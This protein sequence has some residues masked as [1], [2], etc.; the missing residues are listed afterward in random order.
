MDET[1]LRAKKSPYCPL[2]RK[3]LRPQRNCRYGVA[4]MTE[5]MHELDQEKLVALR[6]HTHT[7]TTDT[8]FT[9][10]CVDDASRST[11]VHGA[12]RQK[13]P[14]FP[15]GDNHADTH[16]F[17]ELDRTR[18]ELL[19]ERAANVCRQVHP[20]N[21]SHEVEEVRDEVVRY[22]TILPELFL[23]DCREDIQKA[24]LTNHSHGFDLLRSQNRE[25]STLIRLDDF[26]VDESRLDLELFV[27]GRTLEDGCQQLVKIGSDHVGGLNRFG[28]MSCDPQ[29]DRKLQFFLASSALVCGLAVAV[30]HHASPIY[31]EPF[32]KKLLFH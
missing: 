16:A 9:K 17:V 18:R 4:T 2:S 31:R 12:H 22:T 5:R 27:T 30:G 32:P 21:P 26:D 19:R 15:F 13:A 1:P 7:R 10:R 3:N 14:N 20:S 24:L 6:N 8:L 11:S 29:L 28:Q 25:S 23:H